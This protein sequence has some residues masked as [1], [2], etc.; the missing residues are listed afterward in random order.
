[1]AKTLIALLIATAAVAA[2][3]QKSGP[4]AGDGPATPVAIELFTSQGCSSCPPADAILE[5]LER[6]ANVIVI[7]RPVT[8]W[9]R[10]GWRDTLA[11]EANTSLQRAYATRGGEGSGVYT[12]QA[13]VMGTRGLVG[14]EERQLRAIIAQEKRKPGPSVRA[15]ATPDGGR[16]VSVGE[17][18]AAN[19]SVILVAVKS[20]ASVRIGS[21]ENGG[22]TVSYTNVWQGEREVGR[23]TGKAA[24]FTISGEAMKAFGGDRRVVIIR[25]GA[26][27]RI[28]AARYI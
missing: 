24:T 13:M 12:P 17:G 4:P 10:L 25:A 20:R 21:G 2:V 8:Y 7:G 22:R 14:S 11:K 9:D 16:S 6:E 26:A 23:W 18:S 19:A 5:R 1:M 28:I 27:G 3:A 15:A